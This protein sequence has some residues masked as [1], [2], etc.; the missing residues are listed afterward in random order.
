MIDFYLRTKKILMNLEEIISEAKELQEKLYR[1]RVEFCKN[2]PK[3]KNVK[4][5]GKVVQVQ[6]KRKCER[7]NL[8]RLIENLIFEKGKEFVW[9]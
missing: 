4:K 6:R 8:R 7:R 5:D 9:N 2:N 1:E 3:F